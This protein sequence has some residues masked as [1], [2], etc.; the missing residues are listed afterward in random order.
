[1]A[2]RRPI[3]P[4]GPKDWWED[5]FRKQAELPF[6]WELS[7]V[8]LR[9][10]VE[11]LYEEVKNDIRQLGKPRKSK[12]V[13]PSLHGVC[14]MLCW[15]MLENLLKAVLI[16]RASPLDS[17]GRFILKGHGLLNLADRVGLKLSENE[18][19]LMERLTHF[20]EWAGKYPVPLT[21]EPMLPRTLPQGG[22]A[23][24]HHSLI[25]ADFEGARRIANR[26][27]R[28]LPGKRIR[29]GMP[30]LKKLSTRRRA[31]KTRLLAVR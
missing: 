1:M 31:K 5:Q 17:K 25:G 27:E 29:S 11:V 8:T 30:R 21:N 26:L 9:C 20:V 12:S 15:L 7:A 2:P 18:S 6:M 10:A 28:L 16:S 24:L 13:R 4:R 19:F 3:D 22:F 23:P 14:L